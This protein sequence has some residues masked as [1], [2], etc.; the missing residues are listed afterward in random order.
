VSTLRARGLVWLQGGEG[1][2]G[3]AARKVWSALQGSQGEL[4]VSFRVSLQM[5]LYGHLL[6]EKKGQH[7]KRKYYLSGS[8][9][10]S[11]ATGQLVT[12]LLPTP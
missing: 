5:Y 9:P 4:V 3:L 10:C 1:L 11:K 6:G 12:C 2:G 8:L 7:K